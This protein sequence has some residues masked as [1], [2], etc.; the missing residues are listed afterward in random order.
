MKIK[1]LFSCLLLFLAGCHTGEQSPE[2]GYAFF[3]AGHI[4]GHPTSFQYGVHPPLDS[5]FSFLNKYPGMAF[6]VFTGDV[7]PHPTPDYW[8]SLQADLQKLT[9]PYYIVPGNHDRGPEFEKRYH[10]YYQSFVRNNDLFILLTPNN[11]NIEGPQLDFL[12]SALAASSDSVRNIFI[13]LHELIWWSP[14][15]RFNTVEIN[16]R[17]YYPGTSNFVEEIEPLLRETGKKVV[18]YAGDVGCHSGVSPCMYDTSGN[19]TLIASG[20][21]S[22]NKDNLVITRVYTDGTFNFDLIHLNGPD[23]RGMGRLED[24]SLRT[25]R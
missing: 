13:F 20:M 25:E 1:I 3:V 5:A 14:D 4:Y 15:N 8:D 11:W 19:L 18:V 24:Y 22:G 12:K 2:P 21:G 17:P 16:Y 10:N 7:V 9:V 23:K 6:G